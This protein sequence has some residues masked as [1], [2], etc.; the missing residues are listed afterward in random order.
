MGKCVAYFARFHLHIARQARLFRKRE[1]KRG[2]NLQYPQKSEIEV[3]IK[4][5]Q[6]RKRNNVVARAHSPLST[7][8]CAKCFSMFQHS[9]KMWSLYDVATQREQ[10]FNNKNPPFFCASI[11]TGFYLFCFVLF[12]VFR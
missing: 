7:L 8:Q 4:I 10:F 11:E 2:G 3:E 6:K 12:V 5:N 1:I 9:N